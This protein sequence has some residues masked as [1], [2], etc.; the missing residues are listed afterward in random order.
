MVNFMYIRTPLVLFL[1]L[2]A[3]SNYAQSGEPIE[4][5][6]KNTHFIGGDFYFYA[7]NNENAIV[8]TLENDKIT[9]LSVGPVYGKYFKDNLAWG[10][11]ISYSFRRN[12]NSSGNFISNSNGIGL[13]LFLS[14]NYKIINNL[15]FELEPRLSV[16]YS[17]QKTESLL[18]DNKYTSIGFGLG[19]TPGFL[20]FLNSNFGIR[21]SVGNL[22]YTY[23]RTK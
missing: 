7:S 9:F 5:I 11:S 1:F 17:V 3:H 20:Y 18:T 19:I 12:K 15:F 8:N 14:R 13:A 4:V 6:A 23:S 16:N 21:A 2:L 10:S 22:G